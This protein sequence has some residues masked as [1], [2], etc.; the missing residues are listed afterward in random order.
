MKPSP[1]KR[2]LVKASSGDQAKRLF[3]FE[4]LAFAGELD[5]AKRQ[6]DAL[7]YDEIELQTAAA[8][9]RKVL[10]AEEFRR[11]VFREGLQPKFLDRRSAGARP[12]AP[13]RPAAAAR[14]ERKP[15]RRKRS[16]KPPKPARRSTA[17]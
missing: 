15:R 5:R 10:E 9:Y 1:R 12:P 8:D 11:K 16:P 13:R 4:L 2:P 6:I 3:L 17:S 14:R 7:Q